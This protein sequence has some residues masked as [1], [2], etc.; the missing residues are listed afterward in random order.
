MVD[1]VIP[2]FLASDKHTTSFRNNLKHFGVVSF[3][4]ENGINIGYGY[5]FMKDSMDKSIDRIVKLNRD[6]GESIDVIGW[7]LGG[8]IACDIAR[9]YPFLI[10]SIVTIC[11]PSKK[12]KLSKPNLCII[13]K[14][15][16]V[17]PRLYSYNHNA[18]V[19]IEVENTHTNVI[20]DVSVA[21]IVSEFLKKR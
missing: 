20:N 10:N 17:V 1:I 19:I 9:D 15:D 16:R 18:D 12:Q 6:F 5:G 11:S 7:S 8:T 21:K 4:W 14:N 2:G 3:P 13:S